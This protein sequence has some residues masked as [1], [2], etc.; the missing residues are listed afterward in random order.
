MTGP[1]RYVCDHRL[2]ALEADVTLALSA[3]LLASIC[4]SI[5]TSQAWFGG[6]AC[7]ALVVGFFCF[8]GPALK[9]KNPPTRAQEAP[10][11]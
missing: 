4:L 11:A 10:H 7:L 9:S 5:H 8:A 3:L 2:P 1:R 6:L